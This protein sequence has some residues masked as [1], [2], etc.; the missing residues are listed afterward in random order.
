MAYNDE[1]I[2]QLSTEEAFELLSTTTF[3]RL[4]VRRKDDMDLFPVNFIAHEGALYFR[5]G[6]GSKLFT[7]S[8]NSDVLF[9]ADNVNGEE[10]TAWSV[11]VKGNAKVLTSNEEI[12]AADELP[13]KPWLPTLKYN[14]V[15]IDPSSVS[16]RRFHL[17]EEPERY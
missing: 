10:K 9:E 12:R 16:A 14:Y 7:V 1:V 4:V 15:R 17:G 13:L 11:I 8:L 2:E 5:T 6:E 3:G